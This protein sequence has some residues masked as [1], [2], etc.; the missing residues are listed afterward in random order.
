MKK[1][2][3]LLALSA[4]FAAFG[5]VSWEHNSTSFEGYSNETSLHLVNGVE[6]DE[7]GYE[8]GHPHFFYASDAG[9]VDA[10]EVKT[11]GGDNRA[12]P[13]VQRPAYFA[14]ATPNDNYLE[15]NTAAG[16]LW[17]T[18]G[19]TFNGEIGDSQPIDD[20][21]TYIDTLIQ[22]TPVSAAL[23]IE[24]T[25]EDKLALRLQVETV[26]GVRVTNLVVRALFVDAAGGTDASVATNYTLNTAAPIVPDRWYRLT[27]RAFADV[28]KCQARGASD[29]GLTGFEIYLDG[30]RL[31]TSTPT[32][33]AG[34]IALATS[35]PPTGW[36]DA[37]DDAEGL[38]Y[39]QS[40]TVFP[41][42]LGPTE[43]ATILGIGFQGEG[44]VDDIVLE[45]GNPFPAVTV[46]NVGYDTLEDAFMDIAWGNT[47]TL[48]QDITLTQPLVFDENLP[49]KLTLDL[50]G[51]TLSY[52]TATASDYL[53]TV[54]FD[55]WLIVTN[56]T[57][58][59]PGRGAYV[60]GEL[61]LAAGASLTADC[62]ALHILGVDGRDYMPAVCVV[63]AGATVTHGNGSDKVAVFLS[64][65]DSS[66]PTFYRGWAVLSVNG[67][68]VDAAT[69][70]GQ[71]GITSDGRN[72]SVADIYFYEGSVYTFAD[73]TRPMM[74]LP[75]NN[76]GLYGGTLTSAGGGILLMCGALDVSADSTVQVTANGPAGS[77]VDFD[78]DY[79]ADALY[80]VATGTRYPRSL[81]RNVL[82]AALEG[83][84]PVAVNQITANVAG[85]MFTSAHGA[86]LAA[87]VDT[88]SA[89]TSEIMGF[90][91]GGLFSSE[92][93]STLPVRKYR[94]RALTDPA[95][96]YTV[97]RWLIGSGTQ[98]IPFQITDREDLELFRDQVN[99]NNALGTAGQYFVQTDDIDLGGNVWTDIASPGS[100]TAFSGVYDGDGHVVRNFVLS[101][102]DTCGFFGVIDGGS[103]KNLQL[104]GV[105]SPD[106][107]V[108]GVPAANMKSGAILC[109]DISGPC[110]FENVTVGGTVWGNY[111]VAGIAAWGAGDI[112]MLS[113]TN[114]ANVGTSFTKLGGFFSCYGTS[115]TLFCSNCC[116]KGTLTFDKI[117]RGT[118]PDAVMAAGGF[119]GYQK[120]A[121]AM[122]FVDCAN[123]GAINASY[124]SGPVGTATL[125][126]FVGCVLSGTAS[127]AVTNG[128][129]SGAIA[130]NVANVDEGVEL[131][132]FV[133]YLAD[134]AALSLDNVTV[135]AGTTFSATVAQSVT[136]YVR[137][138]VGYDHT[139]TQT[140]LL[141]YGV[142]PS[143]YEPGIVADIPGGYSHTSTANGLTTYSTASPFSV[144]WDTDADASAIWGATAPS[145]EELADAEAW[146]TANGIA[147][148]NGKLGLESYL[149]GCTSLLAVDPVLKIE[150]I[151]QVASG[152]S[153]TVSA[154]A[155]NAAVPLSSAING[156]LKVR[157][158]AALGGTWTE[159][160]YTPTFTNGKATLTV[161]A[162]GAKFIKAVI[163]R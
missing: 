56:G 94:T 36:L 40:G 136:P 1:C 75:Q 117:R 46:G 53:I 41:S 6:Y 68:I 50:G 8:K 22:F 62:R 137:A 132:G 134:G 155:G 77:Y 59:T 55:N 162:P 123:E 84:S 11:F 97:Y 125:G 145:A 9:S 138:F 47:L 110:L 60:R 144:D 141:T 93:A 51:H 160:T 3:C 122:T 67:T 124:T 88:K 96:Y 39:F 12:A 158:A 140:A 128:V 154:S 78:S 70:P 121:C 17:R 83:G 58:S 91:S 16:I 99:N 156:T 79:S 10:S 89:G 25:A 149:F 14:T 107:Y 5:I 65:S 139:A 35:T 43:D 49:T 159:A 66:T 116:N 21:G 111:N 4:S 2:L 32:F 153:I 34:Y 87:Y 147:D 20:A 61:D 38:A 95:G 74:W 112:T 86:G 69:T 101:G 119:V 48:L 103:V 15:V 114:L 19:E 106:T 151:E 73:A 161:T 104:L 146:A 24:T 33:G 131:G 85:G 133:G 76:L 157:H 71:R 143:Q 54:D 152:W 108:A 102:M 127:V 23:P 115:G 72:A 142:A 148:V 13:A 30:V 130:A 82:P 29:K 150:S 63:G 92:P 126:G 80:L 118:S 64:G 18:F 57:L 27:V 26:G 28:T 90:V 120:D 37:D 109:G 129:S 135:P 98:A 81:Y 45:D 105:R 44:A 113:C 42:L 100:G 52:P 7:E 163:T 31:A